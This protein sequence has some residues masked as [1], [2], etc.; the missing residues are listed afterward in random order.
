[1]IHTASL[2]HDDVV[3]T[4]DTRRGKDSVNQVFG[5]KLAVLAGDFVLARASLSLARLRNIEVCVGS[6]LWVCQS[7]C[8]C[9]CRVSCDFVRYHS[10]CD[11]SAKL[12]I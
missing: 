11:C 4:A 3:D 5:N 10:Q 7:V 2:L 12:H 6:S 8:L 1:L 9:V